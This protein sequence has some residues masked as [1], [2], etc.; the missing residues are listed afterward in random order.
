MRIE[1]KKTS[2]RG[3]SLKG[4][5]LFAKPRGGAEYRPGPPPVTRKPPR[6]LKR[7]M[8]APYPG[9]MRRYDAYAGTENQTSLP[10]IT[11]AKPMEFKPERVEYPRVGVEEEVKQEEEEA[12]TPPGL[13]TPKGEYEPSR[14]DWR[15]LASR[16]TNVI[17]TAVTLPWQSTTDILFGWTHMVQPTI[18]GDYIRARG[19]ATVSRDIAL[20]LILGDY[21]RPLIDAARAYSGFGNTLDAAI[22]DFLIPGAR[23]I[24]QGVF[25]TTAVL[26]SAAIGGEGVQQIRDIYNAAARYGTTAINVGASV[27]QGAVYA[28]GFYTL[29]RATQLAIDNNVNPLALLDAPSVTATQPLLEFPT[30]T[31][32]GDVIGQGGA[33]QRF[34]MTALQ[35]AANMPGNIQQRIRNAVNRMAP[36]AI[37]AAVVIY[38]LRPNV[39]GRGPGQ[40]G[41]YANM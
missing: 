31:T 5:Y 19:H 32:G 17:T 28:G 30:A 8:M 12:G 6:Y 35:A 13:S 24:R 7:L 14:V 36:A 34:M 37:P 26:G 21:A 23:R 33:I 41:A 29:E 40:I 16:A 22:A 20:T 27:G 39:V 25:D 3:G 38:N 15:Q 4:K 11:S 1:K 2:P 9:M 10:P 18:V